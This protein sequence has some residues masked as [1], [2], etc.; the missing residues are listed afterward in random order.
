MK[1][2]DVVIV[3][4]GFAGLN[5]AL[6]LGR[7]RR[8]VLVSD[9]GKK[10]NAVAQESHG[11]LTRDGT[12]HAQLVRIGHEQLRPYETVE[13]CSAGVKAAKAQSKG[14]EINLDDETRI[15]CR[16][17]L[18]ASGVVDEMPEIEG[19]KELW[20][21]SIFHCPFCHGWEVRDQPLALYGNGAA[22]FELAE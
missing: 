14:F 8:R 5:D 10:R 11:F 2:Y 17:L 7:S 19:F 18:L 3:G 1:N 13:L 20:G 21:K 15:A 12:S 6:V 16:K 9:T 22:G 4:G